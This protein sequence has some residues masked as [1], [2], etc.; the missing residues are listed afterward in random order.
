MTLRASR[1]PG[2]SIM[3]RNHK[4]AESQLDAGGAERLPSMTAQGRSER[5]VGG[6]PE[7]PFSRRSF[8]K[9]R[10]CFRLV[11]SLVVLGAGCGGGSS[12]ADGGL[13]GAPDA[14]REVTPPVV[15]A[16]DEPGA[17]SL[18]FDGAALYWLQLND[19]SVRRLALDEE[20]PVTLGSV[21]GAWALAIDAETLLVTTSNGAAVAM[22]VGGGA[23]TVLSGEGIYADWPAVHGSTLY[24]VDAPEAAIKR[25][26]VSGGTVEILPSD[27]YV[28]S[29]AVD[30][31]ALYVATTV[32]TTLSAVPHDGGPTVVLVT[33]EGVNG[34]GVDGTVGI[35]VAGPH[36]YFATVA[37]DV[38]RVPTTGGDVET[39]AELQEIADLA[40]SDDG[41][42]YGIGND[43]M[44]W[45]VV[46][47]EA[48]R[49]LGAFAPSPDHDVSIAV[50]PRGAYI[51]DG[52]A[53]WAVPLD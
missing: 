20:V 4:E 8:M 30:E 53:V 6:D 50:G 40:V 46:P 7:S 33:G 45:A 24:W 21:S 41:T 42:V 49:L 10:L 5:A 17:R 44:L 15:L 3:T 31:H 34:E 47:G 19:G 11:L 52:E 29:I 12:A 32:G 18:V 9:T 38:A 43:G 48:P 27:P 28:G 35:V 22:P 25:V 36:V 26:P 13:P 23:T 39:L 2:V 1:G 14:A 16:P 37:G 51:T